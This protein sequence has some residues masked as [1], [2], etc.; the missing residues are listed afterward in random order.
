MAACFADLGDELLAHV[1]GFAAPRD[2]EALTVASPVVA[3]DVVPWFP[4][5]WKSTFRRRWEALN[6]PLDGV[7][8]GDA[9]LQID[10]NLNALFPRSPSL[11]EM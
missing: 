11:V 2:V 3:R 10:E 7:G 1:L 9:L 8:R 6:F 5:I 4:T